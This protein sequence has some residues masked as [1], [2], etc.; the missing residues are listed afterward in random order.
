[1]KVGSKQ[2]HTVLQEMGGMEARRLL[3]E[4]RQRLAGSKVGSRLPRR[5]GFYVNNRISCW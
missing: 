1:M 2:S 3:L 4:V 5:R